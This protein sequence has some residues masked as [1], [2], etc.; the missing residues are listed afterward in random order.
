MGRLADL[1]N[2]GKAQDWGYNDA[3]RNHY[4]RLWKD[5]DSESRPIQS[6]IESPDWYAFVDSHE[7]EH[8]VVTRKIVTLERF[9]AKF[10]LSKER[11]TGEY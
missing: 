2:S 11:T 8:T 9:V 3:R 10:L 6:T 4:Q 1:L 7:R 5:W